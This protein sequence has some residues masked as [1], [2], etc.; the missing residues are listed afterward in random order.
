MKKMLLGIFLLL[1]SIWCLIFGKLDDLVILL[2][3]GSLLPVVA[4]PVFFF[5]FFHKDS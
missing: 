1:L 3:A 5:G 2:F 4:I